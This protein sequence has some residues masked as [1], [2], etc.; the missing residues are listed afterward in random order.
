LF[1]EGAFIVGRTDTL[2]M[3]FYHKH[4]KPQG[5]VAL[6]GFRNNDRFDGDLYDIHLNNWD[7]N[8]DWKLPKKYD[9]IIS[10]RCPYFAKD[11]YK[12]I[13]KCYENLSPA[14]ILYA[15]WGLGD[16]WRYEDFKV[17][18]IKNK[19]HE[20][21]YAPDNF[22]W[23]TVWDDN[24]LKHEEVK[25]FGERI[26]KFGYNGVKEAVLEEIPSILQLKSVENFFDISYRIV[27]VWEEHP[28][29]YFLIKGKKND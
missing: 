5:D 4:I 20:F 17:G 7:I 26:K 24:F 28:Q 6:L 27:A 13:E 25:L 9:T 21:A 12:F 18:W 16:H 19:E 8:S 10:L 2:I 11:P 3:P 29:L 1:F 15:D 22:L 23:S 14:G